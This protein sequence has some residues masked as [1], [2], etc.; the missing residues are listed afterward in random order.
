VKAWLA[1]SAALVPTLAWA[2]PMCA[3]RGDGNKAATFALI[4]AFLAVPY[5][6]GTVVV[7]LV[8]RLDDGNP[9]E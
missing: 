6:V 1:V 7:R 3:E 2:C 9:E 4:A 8:R 5:A